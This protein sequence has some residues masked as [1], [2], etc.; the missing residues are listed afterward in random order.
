[1]WQD[2]LDPIL[3]CV[4]GAA[5]EARDTNTRRVAQAIWYY[6]RQ[7]GSEEQTPLCRL[8]AEEVLVLIVA[9]SPQATSVEKAKRLVR[10]WAVKAH[11]EHLA[12]LEAHHAAYLHRVAELDELQPPQPNTTPSLCSS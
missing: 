11:H 4:L 10:R 6:T 9:F 3:G 8:L 2:R 1:M 12:M 5:L 7:G